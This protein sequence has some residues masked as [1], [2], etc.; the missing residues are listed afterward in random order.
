MKNDQSIKKRFVFIISL[1]IAVAALLAFTLWR[2]GAVTQNLVEINKARYT[3]YLLA[4]E[5]RQSSDDLTRLARTYVVTGDP[6]YEREY[7]ELLDIRNGKLPRPLDY[8]KIYWDFRAA[9][10]DVP[11][12]S[13][14][15]ISLR[16]LMEKAGF[17]AAEFAKL[18]EAENN[19]N[20]LVHAE[21]TAMNLVKGRYADGKGGYTVVGAPDLEKAREMMHDKQYHIAKGKIVKPMNDFLHLL[22]DRTAE[23]VAKADQERRFWYS[24]LLGVAGAMVLVAALGLWWF[25]EQVMKLLGGEP[26]YAVQIA[27][28]IARGDL[29]Q[30]VRADSADPDSLLNVMRRMQE[31]LARTVAGIRAGAESISSASHEVAAGNSDLSAR[32]EAQASSVEQTASSMAELGSA[33]RQ[34]AEGAIQAN[35]LAQSAS[36]IALDGGE[37]VAEVVQTM[38]SINESSSRIGDIIGVIDSI[39][40][41]TN[42]LALNAAVEAARAG[43]QGRGFAVVASE[44]RL[45]AQRSADAAKEIKQLIMTSLE[46]VGQGTQLVDRAGNTMSEV[47]TAI[48]RVT[49]IMGEISAASDEQNVGV[50]QVGQAVVQ[51]DQSTQQNA[52][53]VEE[54][55][56]AASSMHRQAQALLE[57]VAVFRLPDAVSQGASPG[58]RDEAEPMLRLPA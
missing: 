52:A 58:V 36:S 43:E 32:T 28:G 8:E 23:A 17:S 51:M 39:A 50:A 1:V 54:M 19:S 13:G 27:A 31:S 38:K 10:M 15:S 12:S 9:G 46:R 45:L 30:V 6:E 14:Q 4:D 33:V 53:L 55:A 21:T 40:F 44:V 2:L 34:N 11:K 7:F 25:K 35:R 57:G 18:K 49:E 24:M 26:R 41:Q 5:L 37:V 56:A 20:E 16:A 22:D 42:I 3:A 47:V 29:T 48:G